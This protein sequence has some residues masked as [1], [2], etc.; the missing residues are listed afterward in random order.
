MGFL[1]GGHLTFE[2]AWAWSKFARTV[3]GSDSIDFRSRRASEEERS[4]LASYVAGSGLA[5]SRT[6]DLESAGQVLLVALEPE[7]ECGAMFLRLRKGH[8]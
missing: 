2:D 6:R 5:T 3:V 4:F 7:D 8:A 1:P